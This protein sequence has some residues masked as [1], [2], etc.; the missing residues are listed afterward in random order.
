MP[1]KLHKKELKGPNCFLC[2]SKMCLAFQ[3][4][5]QDPER[6]RQRSISPRPPSG[7]SSV[8]GENGFSLQLT[9]LSWLSC[10][11][12]GVANGFS[13]KK[14]QFLTQSAFNWCSGKLSDLWSMN[15]FYVKMNLPPSF[16]QTCLHCGS[17]LHTNFSVEL[18]YKK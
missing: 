8:T 10:C 15:L 17:F 18:F 14:C 6:K 13:A 7:V 4:I 9:A 16:L 5:N 2:S 12:R 11:T 1:F 3:N